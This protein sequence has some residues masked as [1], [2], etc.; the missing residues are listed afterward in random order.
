[1]AERIFAFGIQIALTMVILYA[2]RYRKNIYLFIAIIVHALI[3][4][5]AGLYQTKIITSI[6]VVE[7]I[8]ALYFII[9]IIFIYKTKKIF[10]KAL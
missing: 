2:V 9:A 1:M 3:D 7:G 5:I 6:Y 8:V 4:V 10:S